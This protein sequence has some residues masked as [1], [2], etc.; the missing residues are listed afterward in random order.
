[1]CALRFCCSGLQCSRIQ[2][3]SG[4][5][6]DVASLSLQHRKRFRHLLAWIGRA[7]FAVV[8]LQFWK[9]PRT[10]CSLQYAVVQGSCPYLLRTDEGFGNGCKRLRRHSLPH[11]PT[12]CFA[13]GLG[14]ISP[15]PKS[16]DWLRWPSKMLRRPASSE[17]RVFFLSRV[18]WEGTAI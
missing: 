18:V 17:G 6:C 15:C 14:D 2:I 7:A 11:W 13:D 5:F 1:M 8:L 10:C 9:S 3:E 4:Y 16:S 12:T